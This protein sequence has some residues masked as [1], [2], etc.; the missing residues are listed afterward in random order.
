MA[1]TTPPDGAGRR[2]D[3]SLDEALQETFPA[4]DPIAFTPRRGGKEAHQVSEEQRSQLREWWH[5]ILSRIT[6]RPSH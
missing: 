1:R 6:N 3:K 5:D 4:S 2:A